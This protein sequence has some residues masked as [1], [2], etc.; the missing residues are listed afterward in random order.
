MMLVVVAMMAGSAGA[1]LT[2]QTKLLAGDGAAGDEFGIFVSL[3]GNFGPG[4]IEGNT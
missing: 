4:S 1:A 2:E 3:S